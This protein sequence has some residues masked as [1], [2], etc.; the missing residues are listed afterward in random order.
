MP[1]PLLLDAL[2]T[3]GLVAVAELGDKSQLVCMTLAAR[4][5]GLPVLL[6]AL[7]AF[8]LLNLIAVGFGA[9]VGHW[10]PEPLVAA[11][12]A[13]LFAG[14]ALRAWRAAAVP[15]DAGELGAP[16]GRGV[17]LTT[18]GLI[19]I[20]EFGDKTQ[21]AVAALSGTAN[22]L[23]VW[24][25]A[26]LA[27]G[28]TSLLGVVAGRTLLQRLPLLWVHR[29]AALLFAVFAVFAAGQAVRGLGGI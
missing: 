16:R 5:R 18:F 22:P 11:V 25:G 9:A 14:F 10:L 23:A 2:S 21:L 19:F 8:M 6:G 12:V 28:L 15:E 1:Q 24:V 4:H 20:A 26:T 13:A 17:L 27:L 3:L 7:A 29:L